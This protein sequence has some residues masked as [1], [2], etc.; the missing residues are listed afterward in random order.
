ML[1]LEKLIF[2]KS[3]HITAD[4]ELADL[5]AESLEGYPV[6]TGGPVDVR[7]SVRHSLSGHLSPIPRSQNPHL[8]HRYDSSFL[9]DFGTMA[10]HWDPPRT[11]KSELGANISIPWSHGLTARPR[12]F[13]SR[14]RSMEFSTDVEVFEQLFHELFLIPS[15]YF[16]PDLVPI[17]AAALSFNGACFLL[18]GTGGTGKTSALLN[19]RDQ[20]GVAF[21]SDDISVISADGLV[22]PN[23]AWPKVYGYNVAGSPLLRKK[24]LVGRNL[25]DRLHFHVRCRISP[26]NV[27]RKIRPRLLFRNVEQ[28]GSRLACV[29][30]LF[31]EDAK[32]FDIRDLTPDQAVAM[33]I[34]VMESEYFTFHNFLHWEAFNSLARGLEPLLDFAVIKESWRKNLL[35]AWND[36]PLKLIRIPL[37]APHHVVQAEIQGILSAQEASSRGAG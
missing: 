4:S 1:I 32:H 16:F 17:H 18:G 5:A 25:L 15:T 9:T 11:G 36:V 19:S 27:R 37:Q 26:T 30:M 7:V 23:L 21:L 20:P 29:N 10:V 31:R 6:S 3:Y 24:I 12:S 13:L 34:A 2:G 33:S 14:A 22:H 28:Y 35:R 8:Y